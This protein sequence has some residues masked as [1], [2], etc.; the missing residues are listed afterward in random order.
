MN[1]QETFCLLGDGCQNNVNVSHLMNDVLNF[2]ELCNIPLQLF[3]TCELSL[4]I[5]LN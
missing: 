5:T 1:E 2:N 3:Y 4:K